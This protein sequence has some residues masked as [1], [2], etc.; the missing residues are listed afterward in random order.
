MQK[1]K[2]NECKENRKNQL[3]INYELVFRNITS[4]VIARHVLV[5]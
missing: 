4:I 3:I 2:I 1:E 5:E